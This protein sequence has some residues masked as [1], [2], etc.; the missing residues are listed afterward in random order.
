[1]IFSKGGEVVG[2]GMGRLGMWRGA[3]RAW[4]ALFS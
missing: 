3:D 4:R 2:G 1:M